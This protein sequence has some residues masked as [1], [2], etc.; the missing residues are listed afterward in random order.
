MTAH[1][2][3]EKIRTNTTDNYPKILKRY[4]FEYANG[5]RSGR[6]N[7]AEMIEKEISE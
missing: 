6:L 1:E 3:A 5:W 4:G 7:S 2:A